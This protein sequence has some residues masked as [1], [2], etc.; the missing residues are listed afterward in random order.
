MTKDK[1]LKLLRPVTRDDKPL[2][3]RYLSQYE[4]K[5]SELTFTN[6]FCWSE[7][8]HYLFG[9]C[10]EH[11]LIAYREN[12]C[13]LSLLPPV[14]PRPA[15]IVKKRMEGFRDYCWTRLDEELAT[16]LGPEVRLIP[17]RKNSDYV[18]RLADLRALPGREFH[19]K[20]NL[21]KRFAVLQPETRPLTSALLN[22]CIHIQEQWLESQRNNESARNESAALIKALHHFEP[23]ALHGIGVFTKGSL[24]GFAIG[25]R[26]NS[27][28]FVEHFEKALPEFTGAYQYLLQAFAQSIPDSF[29]YLNREQDL[30]LDGL[31]RAKESWHPALMVDKYTLKVRCQAP[32]RASAAAS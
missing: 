14:G 1:L 6:I 21:I 8:K 25:E 12:D 16:R 17:D 27:S 26:L 23:L 11:L 4:S 18:Y 13:C 24:V 19:A 28:T 15:S 29:T 7:I 32:V 3:D 30:G 5:I 20:R 2:F 31:R 22:E 10:R 9:E